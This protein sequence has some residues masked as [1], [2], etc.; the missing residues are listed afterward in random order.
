MELIYEKC[1]SVNND[2]WP[3]VQDMKGY[4]LYGPKKPYPRK[5]REYLHTNSPDGKMT[6]ELVD[7]IDKLL[8][9]DPR[10]RLTAT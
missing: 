10:K 3:G 4:S 9:M 6:D 7:L 1:G 8:R 2:N 5:I